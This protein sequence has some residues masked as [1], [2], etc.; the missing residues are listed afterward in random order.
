VKNAKENAS[1][2][3]VRQVQE[4]LG[5]KASVDEVAL[6]LKCSVDTVRSAKYGRRSLPLMSAIAGAMAIGE[7][8][9]EAAAL[10]LMEEAKA[11]G[12]KAGEQVL[13]EAADRLRIKPKSN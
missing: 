8:G 13:K 12:W 1:Q 9:G 5:K 11:I 3:L 4:M 7:S 2:R 10:M 6:V